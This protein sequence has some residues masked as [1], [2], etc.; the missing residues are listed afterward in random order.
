MPCVVGSRS[1]ALVALVW[2]WPATPV[3]HASTFVSYYGGVDRCGTPYLTG[4]VWTAAPG[5]LNRMVILGGQEALKGVTCG[6]GGSVLVH[7]DRNPIDDVFN[8]CLRIN[9]RNLYCGNATRFEID[10]G[11]NNDTLVIDNPWRDTIV[12]G[13]GTD[14]VYVGPEDNV[15]ASCEN[16]N[17]VG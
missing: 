9:K 14:T 11:D 10:L 13:S 16:V 12:C 6:H 5:E 3:A 17:I 2:A 8:A 4:F 1:G 7:D 15:E